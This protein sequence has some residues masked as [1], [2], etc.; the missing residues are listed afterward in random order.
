[1]PALD[2]LELDGHLL[3]RQYVVAEVDVSE[4][5]AANLLAQSVLAAHPQLHLVAGRRRRRG[6]RQRGGG[7]GGGRRIERQR[8]RRRRHGE[9]KQL[10]SGDG[11]QSRPTMSQNNSGPQSGG[12][13]QRAKQSGEAVGRLTARRRQRD[14]SV[15]AVGTPRTCSLR[16]AARDCRSLTPSQHATS[17]AYPSIHHRDTRFS[18]DGSIER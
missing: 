17:A 9:R 11:E 6:R 15:V 16:M 18:K 3:T 14:Y 1:M 10:C 13:S 4:R 2:A 7:G 8:R 5:A 12:A